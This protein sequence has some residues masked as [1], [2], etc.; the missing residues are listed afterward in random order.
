LKFKTKKIS[1]LDLVI[2]SG[3]AK[4]KSE[5]RRL[6]LQNAVSI[7]DQTKEN[8]SEVLSLGGGEVL[9]I[10]KKNFFRIQA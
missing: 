3:V 8:P 9:K 4:S 2:A 6:V 5:A 1:V 7:D 10:G